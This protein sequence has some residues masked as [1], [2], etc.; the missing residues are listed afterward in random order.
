[1]EQTYLNQYDKDT[2]CLCK[3]VMGEDIS[4]WD[5]SWNKSEF[6]DGLPTS[7]ICNKE[8]LNEVA[9]VITFWEARRYYD[10]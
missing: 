3:L 9:P 7:F 5:N 6:I 4:V 8:Q 10:L 1:M 2:D